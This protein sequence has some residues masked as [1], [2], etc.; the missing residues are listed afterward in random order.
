MKVFVT[1][2]IIELDSC[3]QA[4]SYFSIVLNSTLVFARWI[5]EQ[6]FANVY[7]IQPRPV[8]AE[9]TVSWKSYLYRASPKIQ[10]PRF[11]NG[12]DTTLKLCNF[13]DGDPFSSGAAKAAWALN[14]LLACF[15]AAGFLHGGIKKGSS[16][17]LD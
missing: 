12:L 3:G 14:H 11:F 4:A 1:E 5:L 9:C 16:C 13:A 2:K 8:Y 17:F 15:E 7:T 10:I 6:S